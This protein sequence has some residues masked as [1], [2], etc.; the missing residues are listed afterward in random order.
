M[1]EKRAALSPVPG[2]IG[3]RANS[4]GQG[5]YPRGDD[6]SRSEK[7][8]K[9]QNQHPNDAQSSLRGSKPC[10]SVDLG[11][12]GESWKGDCSS[13]ESDKC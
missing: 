13:L 5:S 2:S 1:G 9:Q 8:E 4:G 12:H 10:R 11:I 3:Q 6:N 7:R